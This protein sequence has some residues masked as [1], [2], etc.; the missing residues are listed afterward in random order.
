VH[1][2]FPSVYDPFFDDPSEQ[3]IKECLWKRTEGRRST[4]FRVR[5][6]RE[7]LARPGEY[8]PVTIDQ[9]ANGMVLVYRINS[10]TSFEAVKEYARAQK[11]ENGGILSPKPL[12]LVGNMVDCKRKDRKILCIEAEEFAA[13]LGCV[14]VETSAKESKGIHK[15]KQAALAKMATQKDE[16]ISLELGLIARKSRPR[17]IQG[18]DR[19]AKES[20]EKRNSFVGRLSALRLSRAPRKKKSNNSLSSRKSTI[21]SIAEEPDETSSEGRTATLATIKETIHSAN[22]SDAGSES[23]SSP[24]SPQSDSSTFSKFSSASSQ[25]SASSQSSHSPRNSS[26]TTADDRSIYTVYEDEPGFN[27]NKPLPPVPQNYAL[28]P[29][30]VLYETPIGS[31]DA[32]L[33]S[34]KLENPSSAHKRNDSMEPVTPAEDPTPP[35]S[36]TPKVK[37]SSAQPSEPHPVPPPLNLHPALNQSP[38]PAIPTRSPRRGVSRPNSIYDSHPAMPSRS[39]SVRSTSTTASTNAN[40]GV[41]LPPLSRESAARARQNILLQIAALMQTQNEMEILQQEATE[42]TLDDVVNAPLSEEQPV[43]P[44]PTPDDDALKLEEEITAL[45]ARLREAEERK[46]MLQTTPP[47]KPAEEF[48]ADH[49]LGPILARPAHTPLG[50]SV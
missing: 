14:F 8:R 20:F 38:A 34:R 9:N 46:A 16:L 44:S 27:H 15:L 37:P 4:A 3:N 18:S 19:A 11:R 22:T 39:P 49:R 36:E 41:V 40:I 10:A 42:T 12:A 5:P 24:P 50:I 13:E 48:S 17:V 28:R 30:T 23:S 1:D 31:L 43:S 2:L 7:D 21:T 45:R 26:E 29:P 47:W 33:E 32:V 25:T 6:K 35:S